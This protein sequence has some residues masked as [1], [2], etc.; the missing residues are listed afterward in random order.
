MHPRPMRLGHCGELRHRVNGGGGGGAHCDDHGG[1]SSSRG[2]VCA[3]S[4][5]KGAGSH[6]IGGTVSGDDAQ[7]VGAVAGQQR[8]LGDG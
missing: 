1:W 8:R 7:I 2:D 5:I 4:I 6:G 3:H